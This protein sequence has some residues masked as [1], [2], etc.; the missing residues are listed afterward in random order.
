MLISQE[1]SS[2]QTTEKTYDTNQHPETQSNT[3][4][5]KCLFF[6]NIPLNNASFYFSRYVDFPGGYY[7]ITKVREDRLVHQ[8]SVPKIGGKPEMRSLTRRYSEYMS[9]FGMHDEMAE[10]FTDQNLNYVECNSAYIKVG[11]RLHHHLYAGFIRKGH[12]YDLVFIKLYKREVDLS[13]IFKDYTFGIWSY[14]MRGVPLAQGMVCLKRDQN[15][16]LGFCDIGMVYRFVG[17]HSSLQMV[18]LKQQL[19]LFSQQLIHPRVWGKMQSHTMKCHIVKLC[20]KILDT[21]KRIT[22]AGMQVKD[23]HLSDVIVS[24]SQGGDDLAVHLLIQNHHMGRNTLTTSRDTITKLYLQPFKVLLK[25]VIHLS[26]L[27][28]LKSVLDVFNNMHLDHMGRWRGQVDGSEVKKELSRLE[29][30]FRKKAKEAKA[31]NNI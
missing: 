25:E 23:L 10:V 30:K 1:C 18:N 24:L 21:L 28:T 16:H 14:G 7:P 13:N 6:L 3:H 19:Q 17:H 20:M 15:Q 12:C 9:R 8:E 5:R 2:P 4:R 26:G 27:S 31:R 22:K 29:F 11:S